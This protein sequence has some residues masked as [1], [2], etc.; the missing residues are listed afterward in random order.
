M[1]KQQVYGDYTFKTRELYP[2]WSVRCRDEMDFMEGK[3]VRVVRLDHRYKKGD[4]W[5]WLMAW[6]TVTHFDREVM[7]HVLGGLRSEIQS[8]K[9]NS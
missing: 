1:K 5:E 4:R 8:L 6:T 2:R 9:H 7:A 3:E